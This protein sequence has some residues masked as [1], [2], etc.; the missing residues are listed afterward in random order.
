LPTPTI[1]SLTKL[2]HPSITEF[3]TTPTLDRQQ[4]VSD[5]VSVLRE[6]ITKLSDSPRLADEFQCRVGRLN[7][8]CSP[9]IKEI[10]GTLG[11]NL[12]RADNEIGGT[13]LTLRPTQDLTDRSLRL[14]QLALEATLSLGGKS[15]C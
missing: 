10:L 6:A 9:H 15:S 1:H 3:A 7:G 2:L 8:V 13:L 12:V 5:I 11:L 14:L 4:I